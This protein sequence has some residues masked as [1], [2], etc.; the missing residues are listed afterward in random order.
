[1]GGGEPEGQGGQIDPGTL[2]VVA[3]VPLLKG[4]PAQVAF[5]EGFVWVTDT[6]DNSVTRIDPSSGGGTTIDAVGDGPVGVA[7]GNGAAWVANG[8]DGTV[9]EI[10]PRSAKVVKRFTLGASLSP[11]GVA[12]T[13]GAVW[14]TVHSP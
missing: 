9:A 11:D 6:A 12:V 10:D 14:V 5:G 4:N 3:T 2:K 13:A 7:A 1:V 8:R